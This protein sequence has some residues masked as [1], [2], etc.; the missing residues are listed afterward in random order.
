M[1]QYPALHF[2]GSWESGPCSWVLSTEER[3]ISPSALKRGQ[4]GFRSLLV[5]LTH[6]E[7]ATAENACFLEQE[8]NNSQIRL[9]WF[10]TYFSFAKI[11]KEGKTRERVHFLLYSDCSLEAVAAMTTHP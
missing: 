10:L 5:L 8:L 1:R 11:L 3:V 7:A 6:L 4:N 2:W 9:L